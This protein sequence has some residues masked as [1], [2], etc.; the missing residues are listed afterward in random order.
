MMLPRTPP[1]DEQIRRQLKQV[2]ELDLKH[3]EA[4]EHLLYMFEWDARALQQK[5]DQEDRK[6]GTT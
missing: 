1:N 5:H 3:R 2:R 4:F 6:D